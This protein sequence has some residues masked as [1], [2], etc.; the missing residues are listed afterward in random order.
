MIHPKYTYISPSDKGNVNIVESS[1]RFESYISLSGRKSD[2]SD[3][4]LTEEDMPHSH[5]WKGEKEAT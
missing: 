3:K 5:E 4:H 2:D 1:T